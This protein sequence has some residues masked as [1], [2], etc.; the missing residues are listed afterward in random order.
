MT[1]KN[2]ISSDSDPSKKVSYT[3]PCASSFRDAVGELAK[4]K[5]CNVADIARS[6][7]LSLP[8]EIVSGFPDPGE[9][10]RDDRETVILKSGKSIG[11]PWRRKPRL[12]VRLS[13]GFDVVT[14]R[15]A[16]ALGIAL[17]QGRMRLEIQSPAERRSREM[18]TE[19][20]AALLRD[21]HDEL[22][23]M[24]KVVTAITFEPLKGGVSSREQALYV[25]GFQP[26]SIPDINTIRLRFRRLATVYHPDGKLGSHERMSQLN[27]AMEH[28]SRGKF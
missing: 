14:I 18:E 3:V 17:H 24:K 2:E 5:N 25:L 21:T 13:P 28:L 10:A 26:G 1:N 4:D 7:V 16:L 15:K 6:I 20:Q 27:A 11:K 9:P 22:E 23:S 12:Q 8:K 19:A